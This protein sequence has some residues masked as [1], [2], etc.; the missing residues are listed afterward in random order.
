MFGRLS[1][2]E[3]IDACNAHK[4]NQE[5]AIDIMIDVDANIRAAADKIY[6]DNRKRQAQIREQKEAMYASL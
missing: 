3:L 4:N 6:D 2:K 5:R 1:K